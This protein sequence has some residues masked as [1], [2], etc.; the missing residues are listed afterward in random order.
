MIALHEWRRVH[1]GEVD[2]KMLFKRDF[3]LHCS[4]VIAGKRVELKACIHPARQHVDSC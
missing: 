2:G 4:L 1:H 3:S